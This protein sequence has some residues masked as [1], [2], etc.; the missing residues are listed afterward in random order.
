MADVYL[1]RAP[2]EPTGL[3]VIKEPRTGLVLD[4]QMRAMFQR[5]AAVGARMHHPNIVRT[6]ELGAADGRPFIAMEFLD[7]QPLQR[8]V[9]RVWRDH[10]VGLPLPLQLHVL[11]GLLA[12]LH[13]V[14]ESTDDDGRPLGLVHC[15]VTPHNVLVTYDGQVKLIDFGIVGTT[16]TVHSDSADVQVGMFRGKASYC[17]PEQARGDGI[18]RRTDL[19]AVSVMLWEA[20]A[21]RRMWPDLEPTAILRHL[22]AGRVPALPDG[23]EPELRALCRRALAID[24]AQRPASAADFAAQLEAS[25][26]DEDVNRQRLGELLCARF[27]FERAIVRRLVEAEAHDIHES[28]ELDEPDALAAPLLDLALL[29][30]AG[31][32]ADGAGVDDEPTRPDA[33]DTCPC[34]T[35]PRSAAHDLQHPGP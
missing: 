12:G 18:D 29:T 32:F 27:T 11:T 7:G 30:D 16:G 26:P 28:H 25:A 21:Q 1:A 14:H 5:E 33:C 35:L 8:I 3:L 13:H 23:P 17:A 4:P 19:F 6:H 20:L 24:P 22:R 34:Q 10:G 31:G 15:D 2:R 9:R